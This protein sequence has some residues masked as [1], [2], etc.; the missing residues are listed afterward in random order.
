M[1]SVTKKR[2]R[3][4]P[5]SVIAS[6]SATTCC[7][8]PSGHSLTQVLENVRSLQAKGSVDLLISPTSVEIEESIPPLF[9]V[10]AIFNA[11]EA[12]SDIEHKTSSADPS[13]ASRRV[14]CRVSLLHLLRAIR[15]FDSELLFQ[16]LST[17]S[18][19]QLCGPDNGYEQASCSLQLL[20]ELSC[21]T[22]TYSD[23]VA[24]YPWKYSISLQRTAFTLFLKTAQDFDAYTVRFV[25]SS[26]TAGG[27]WFE[28]YAS[29]TVGSMQRK[30]YCSV[31]TDSSMQ[32]LS[33]IRDLFA[34]P[35]DKKNVG[36]VRLQL[37]YTTKKL[38]KF[39]ST[40]SQHVS[41]LT[42]YFSINPLF[43][44]YSLP[45]G[46]VTVAMTSTQTDTDI[47]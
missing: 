39:V 26:V 46:T 42:L 24:Q 44:C 7:T 40:I 6:S 32:I 19:L 17:T 23:V 21:H 13:S 2:K 38:C 45:G 4:A 16:V 41:T 22:H 33:P 18:Q 25:I 31:K 27:A 37:E 34:E 47:F 12:L 29:G 1:S 14:V 9:F 36:E 20:E 11:N 28:M 8:L 43:L 15:L 3:S 35:P 10:K 30:Y 5:K